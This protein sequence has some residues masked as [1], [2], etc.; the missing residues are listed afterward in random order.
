MC[1]LLNGKLVLNNNLCCLCNSIED[2]EHYFIQCTYY[3]S[4][5]SFLEVKLKLIGIQKNIRI[6]RY[7]LLGYKIQDVNYREFNI[8]LNIIGY[9]IY[10]AYH[11]SDQKRKSINLIY[12]FKK[13]LYF[14][15]LCDKKLRNSEKTI[16]Y[17]PTVKNFSFF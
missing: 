5:W 11:I 13:E 6:L 16:K 4:L 12:L 8:L 15:D 10:K 7:I 17:N 2:Y 3:Q 9:V 14:Y 1:Y